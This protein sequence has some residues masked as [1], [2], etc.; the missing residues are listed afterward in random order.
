MKKNLV[1]MPLMLMSTLKAGSIACVIENVEKEEE[2]SWDS[3]MDAIIEVE[4]RGDSLAVCDVYC[5][6][7]QISPIVVDDCNETLAKQGRKLRYTLKDRF[8]VEKSKEM[9]RLLQGR[10]NPE[11]NV[12]KA[13]RLWNGGPSYT[14]RATQTYYN[15]VMSAMASR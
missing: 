7:M 11:Q 1:L 5:G 6:A 14:R 4:S 15:K 2:F 12:E 9:F 8:S 13:I 3:V 10:Y